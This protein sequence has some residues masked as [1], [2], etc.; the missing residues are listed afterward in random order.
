MQL[1]RRAPDAG[2]TAGDE[3]RAAGQAAFAEDVVHPPMIEAGALE[4]TPQ[5]G[6]EARG[7]TSPSL[8][9]GVEMGA[10]FRERKIHSSPNQFNHDWFNIC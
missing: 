9:A 8:S 10:G 4:E 5:E 3:R 2:A 6:A 7:H 1:R